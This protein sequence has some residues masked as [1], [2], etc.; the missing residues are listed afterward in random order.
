MRMFLAGIKP[1]SLILA[2]YFT[3]T[4]EF[5]YRPQIVKA[6]CGGQWILYSVGFTLSEL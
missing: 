4:F 3:V 2:H 5:H 6:N 1:A